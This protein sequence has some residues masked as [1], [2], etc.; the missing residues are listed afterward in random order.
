MTLRVIG[1]GWGRTGTASLREAFGTLGLRSHHMAEVFEHPE[2]ADWF[3]RAAQGDADWDAIY[4]GYD[5][6]V[7]WPGASFWREL[8]QTYPDAKVLLTIR[9]PE[10]WYES[11]FDTI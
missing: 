5:V 11:F 3:A 1:A 7:D 8:A 9:D 4:A 6:T 10:Q 2:Q